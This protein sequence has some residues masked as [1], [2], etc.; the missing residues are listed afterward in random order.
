MKTLADSLP[1]RLAA[2]P[3]A[4]C[5]FAVACVTL[6]R[7]S[8]PPAY[9]SMSYQI[10][11][12]SHKHDAI[13][14]WLLANPEKKMAECARAF[15]VTQ[16]WLS[17]VV[18]SD[19]FQARYKRLLEE[20]RDTRVMP[21]RDKLIGTASRAVEKLGDQIETTDD[22][23]FLLEASDKLLGRLGYGGKAG[24]D[25]GSTLVQNNT[26]VFNGGALTSEQMQ[27]AQ[28]LRAQAQAR[29]E[30][31]QQEGNVLQTLQGSDAE[32][33]E[34]YAESKALEAPQPAKPD[35]ESSS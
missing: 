12:L 5:R 13:M 24:G 18:N 16:T 22:P 14:D 4:S 27:R 20:H 9:V 33:D 2:T 26:M 31:E 15:G 10:S 34:L 3:L 28:A 11:R 35:D 29:L 6:A 1:N 30:A 7:T 8:Q 32:V 19:L 23:S 25:G 21:L 17:I